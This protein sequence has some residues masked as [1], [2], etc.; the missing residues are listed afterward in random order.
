M[1]VLNRSRRM[2]FVFLVG[3]CRFV[4]YNRFGVVGSVAFQN[5]THTVAHAWFLGC[6][7]RASCCFFGSF[8]GCGFVFVFISVFAVFFVFVL[9][10][11]AVLFNFGFGRNFHAAGAYKVYRRKVGNGVT[12]IQ[13]RGRYRRQSTRRWRG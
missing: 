13:G 3:R 11:V 9:I 7:L 5:F 6:R 12:Y 1:N 2:G 4:A 8:F 10:F